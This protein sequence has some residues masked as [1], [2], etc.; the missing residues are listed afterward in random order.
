MFLFALEKLYVC[1]GK[2]PNYM[3]YTSTIQLMVWL[4]N[5]SKVTVLLAQCDHNKSERE[6]ALKPITLNDPNQ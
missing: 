2:I 3:S 1:S 5:T 6:F 4:C